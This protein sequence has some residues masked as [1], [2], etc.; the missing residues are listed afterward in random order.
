MQKNRGAQSKSKTHNVHLHLNTIPPLPMLYY[1]LLFPAHAVNGMHDVFTTYLL[2]IRKPAIILKPPFHFPHGH[3]RVRKLTS[4]V[5][6]AGHM[7]HP[8]NAKVYW[9]I[10]P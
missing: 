3:H 6:K 9:D 7:S 4:I 5:L 2:E 10:V 8:W 1:V